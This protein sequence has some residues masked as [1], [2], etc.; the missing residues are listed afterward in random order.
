MP[1]KR[2]ANRQHLL[3]TATER[4]GDLPPP[5]PQDRKILIH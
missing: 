2:A 4:S 1:Y 5:F 3:L